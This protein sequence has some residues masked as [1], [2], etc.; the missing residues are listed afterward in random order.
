MTDPIRVVVADDHP[1][2]RAGVRALLL[3]LDDLD[4]VGEAADGDEAIAVARATRP[5]VILMDLHMPGT[6]GV[7]ATRSITTELPGTA[8]LVVTMVEDDA[9]VFA[10]MC[11]GARGYLL[12]GADQ[13]ELCRAV[14]AVANGEAIFGSRIAA[15]VLGLLTAPQP[16]P[17]EVPFPQLTD[18][19]RQV[20][21]ELAAGRAN[22]SI[23]RALNVSTR[24]VANHV[25]AIFA[26]LQLADR[27][28]TIVR[29]REAGLGRRGPT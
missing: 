1:L 29:A 19:E 5:D 7:T 3:S 14:S 22:A 8:V 23:A 10:A 26:K 15:R 20:L 25:S 24:T 13:D 9:S 17:P 18:R 28:E 2:I 12:K 4:L 11:A 6:D 16:A 21:D 27:A